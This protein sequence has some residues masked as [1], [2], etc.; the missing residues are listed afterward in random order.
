VN[1]KQRV[2]LA[3]EEIEGAYA[4]TGDPVRMA[5]AAGSVRNAFM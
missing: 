1:A 3:L 4:A 5:T 2:L